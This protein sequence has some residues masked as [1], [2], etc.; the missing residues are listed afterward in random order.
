MG[1][2]LER[3]REIYREIGD[4][5]H[6]MAEAMDAGML[7]EIESGKARAFWHEEIDHMLYELEVH[8]DGDSA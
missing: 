3:A 1:D 7:A 4:S 8:D 5:F 6:E 2:K